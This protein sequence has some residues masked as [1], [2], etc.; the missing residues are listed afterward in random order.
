[1]GGGSECGYETGESSAMNRRDLLIGL[2]T[3]AAGT[4]VVM[5][6]SAFT[7]VSSPRQVTIRVSEDSE[8]LVGLEDGDPDVVRQ[9]DGGELEIT[10]DDFGAFNED[11]KVEIGSTDQ[12]DFGDGDV[13]NPAFTI[14]NNFG[15]EVDEIDVTLDLNGLDGSFDL[16]VTD[17]NTTERLRDNGGEHEFE[18]VG[19]DLEVVIEIDTTDVGSSISGDIEITAEPEGS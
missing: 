12:D 16:A 3:A 2:G 8:A 14:T 18:S 19:D 6:T 10:T 1:M 9:N 11:A 17:S 5:G 4:S 15:D 7:T 13:E